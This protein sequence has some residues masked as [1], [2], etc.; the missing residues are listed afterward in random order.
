MLLHILLRSGAGGTA[1][2]GNAP[3]AHSAV[4]AQGGLGAQGGAVGSDPLTPDLN[5]PNRQ[6]NEQKPMAGALTAT[7]QN[8]AGL[9]FKNV[10]K[11]LLINYLS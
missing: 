10:V 6:I 2:D 4:G 5:R 11:K 3:G 7:G 1:A 9:A 8:Q